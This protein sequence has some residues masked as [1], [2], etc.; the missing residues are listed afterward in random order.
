MLKA[1]Q[2]YSENLRKKKPLSMGEVLK[3]AGYKKSVQLAP[4]NVT[5]SKT[6]L[7]LMEDIL[8]DEYL[9]TKHKQLSNSAKID[10]YVFPLNMKDEEIRDIV[11]SIE[12]CKLRKIVNSVNSKHAYFWMPDNKAIEAAI[13]MGYKLKGKYAAQKV[14]I[15][16]EFENMTDEELFN[17]TIELQNKLKKLH[18][19]P[20]GNTDKTKKA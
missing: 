6:W 12:G 11:E 10:H 9:I 3:R 13:D 19:G 17:K 7:Q 15:E 16:D 14:K 4:Q 5:N 2:V 1:A 20:K 8:P 18:G